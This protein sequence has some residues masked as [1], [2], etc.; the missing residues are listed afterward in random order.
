MLRSSKRARPVI[1]AAVV[2]ALTATGGAAWAFWHLAGTGSVTASAGSAVDLDLSARPRPESPL[3]PGAATDLAVAVRNDNRFPVL[4]TGVTAGSDP[5]TVD[6][7][8]RAAGCL[9]TGV[10]LT[11]RVFSVA[12]R[13]PA[14]SSRNFLLLDAVAMTNASDS[15]CQ[16]GTFTVPLTASG[17]NDAG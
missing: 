2:A 17:I 11:Q 9:T 5:V 10:A 15:A 8:H 6:A 7:P 16:N 3:H 1:V 4:L 14:R 13:I 12:W